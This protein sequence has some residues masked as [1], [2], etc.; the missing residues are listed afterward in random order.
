[1]THSQ[2]A[3]LRCYGRYRNGWWYLYCVDLCLATRRRTLKE[4]QDSLEEDIL[5]FLHAVRPADVRASFRRPPLHALA[6]Y[7]WIWLIAQGM[8][9]TRTLLTFDWRYTGSSLRPAN[10]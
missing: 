3:I 4:A 5:G 10:A 9:A 8:H 1:M 6:E 2:Q 7:Y